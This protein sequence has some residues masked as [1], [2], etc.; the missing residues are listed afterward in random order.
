MPNQTEIKTLINQSDKVITIKSNR[1]YDY[2]PLQNI[3]Y[4][5]AE[6]NYCSLFTIEKKNYLTTNPLKY[7]EALLKDYGFIR[8][9][10]SYIINRKH[11]QHY[12]LDKN[13]VKF[14]NEISIT[15]G[16]KTNPKLLQ[17]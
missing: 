14:T 15:I 8:I 3:V 7:Y 17:L 6:N 4:I 10:R 9:N 11:L 16:N 2:V 1:Y 5:K 13:I 12:N